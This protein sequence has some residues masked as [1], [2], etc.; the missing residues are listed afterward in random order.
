MAESILKKQRAYERIQRCYRGHSK[1]VQKAD[2]C[3]HMYASADQASPADKKSCE[4]R[5]RELFSI[6]TIKPLID[7]ACQ[8]QHDSVIEAFAIPKSRDADDARAA[9]LTKVIKY[10][11]DTNNIKE[12]NDQIYREAQVTGRGFWDIRLGFGRSHSNIFGQIH[13]KKLS[14]RQVMVP[15]EASTT[16]TNDWPDVHIMHHISLAE[17]EDLYGEAAAKKIRAKYSKLGHLSMSGGFSWF[18]NASTFVSTL[19][20]DPSGRIIGE[21]QFTQDEVNSRIYDEDIFVT[22][23][24][25]QFKK[26]E[27]IEH[28]IDT[29]TGES[30]PIPRG[31]E[32][33][34][35]DQITAENPS[36]ITA[37]LMGEVHYIALIGPEGEILH[38]S[39]SPYPFFTVEAYFPDFFDGKTVG[40][41]EFMIQPQRIRNTSL[42]AL[43]NLTLTAS[44]PVHIVN[45]DAVRDAHADQNEISDTLTKKGGV[46]FVAGEW[47]GNAVTPLPPSPVP[48]GTDRLYYH[49][50]EAM[51]E[52]SGVNQYQTGN[53]REDVSGKAIQQN[54]LAGSKGNLHRLHAFAYAYERVVDR[55]ITLIQTFYDYPRKL[56]ITR[57]RGYTGTETLNINMM[58]ALGEL[59]NDL[60]I[61]EFGVKI[62]VSPPTDTAENVAFQELLSLREMGVPVPPELLVDASSIQYKSEVMEALQGPSEAQQA[63]EQELL[64]QQQEALNMDMALKEAQ[65]GE[66]QAKTEKARKEGE[67][68]VASV[69]VKREQVELEKLK[70][71]IMAEGQ[72]MDRTYRVA[73]L[74]QGDRKLRLEHHW[75]AKDAQKTD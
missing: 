19:G 59:E 4:E 51:G 33:E 9:V 7:T 5:D 1:F 29:T 45:L 12:I 27:K 15:P 68:A 2:E 52:V 36:M 46:L 64:R 32:R 3:A 71:Q 34:R 40:M 62:K 63:Q 39:E 37:K 17:L 66:V 56:H 61:G 14:C 30:R 48:T 74:K 8:E 16:R 24:E 47:N 22:L 60:T 49:A 20:N 43:M 54:Q 11:E 44:N 10:T 53:T 58:N 75:R 31:W 50:S 18:P 55:M 42:S 28:L 65:I 70:V 23:V 25:R 67:A 13:V 72:Q 73:Q 41:V 57:G 35:I 6:N 21:R 69:E 38:E 26:R